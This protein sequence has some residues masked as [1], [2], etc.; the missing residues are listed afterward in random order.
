[1]LIREE[2]INAWYIYIVLK[3]KHFIQLNCPHIYKQD[4]QTHNNI[5]YRYQ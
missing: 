5:I 4:P 3:R 2:I 1:M